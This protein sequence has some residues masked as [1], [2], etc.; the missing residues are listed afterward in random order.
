MP[1]KNTKS[2][3]YQGVLMCKVGEETDAC[4]ERLRERGW[5]LEVGTFTVGDDRVVRPDEKDEEDDDTVKE[6]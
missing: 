6:S 4:L 3:V 5:E 2:G 1:F